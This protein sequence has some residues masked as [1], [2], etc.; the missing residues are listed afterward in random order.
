[1]VVAAMTAPAV[2]IVVGAV[3]ATL[4]VGAFEGPGWRWGWLG[5]READMALGTG[6]LLHAIAAPWGVGP[7]DDDSHGGLARLVAEAA[8]SGVSH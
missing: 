2:F 3:S 5:I 7:G 1:M 6:L 4:T 8:H